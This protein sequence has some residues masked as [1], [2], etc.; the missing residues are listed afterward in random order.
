MNDTMKIEIA[1]SAGI[2]YTADA[3]MVTLPAVDGRISIFAHHMPMLTRITPGELI[4]RT[5]DGQDDVLAVGEG[6]VA[7]TSN[8]IGIVTDTA[9]AGRDARAPVRKQR[10]S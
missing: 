3:R 8:H 6:L 1:T 10:R 9:I 2:V 7:V 5:S 4:V